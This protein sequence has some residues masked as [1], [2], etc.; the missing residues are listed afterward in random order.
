[1]G[2]LRFGSA[3][4]TAREIDL[5]TPTTAAP[6]GV[7]A[8]I[9]GTA[10]RGPAF[11]PITVG[12]V[13]NFYL[14]FG[15]TDGK[16]FGPLAVTEWLRNAGAVTYM[17]VMG[18]GDGNMRVAD[19]TYAGSVNKAGFV[20]GED[21]PNSTS[22]FLSR[23]PY[24]NYGGPSGRTFF[25]GCLMSESAGSTVFSSAG[26]QQ[27]GVAAPIIRGVIMAA[28]GVIL[29]LS[30]STAASSNA[31][32]ATLVASDANAQGSLTGSVSL[33][34][35][36]TAK[37]E[38]VLLLNGHVGNDSLYPNVISASFDM[39]SNNY[40]A[41]MLNKD[42]LNIQKAGHC[43]YAYWDVYPATAAVTGSGVIATSVG[44]G[45]GAA[46]GFELAA[47][48]T[49]GSV[50]RNTGTATVPNFEN[51]Q[52]R[53][54]YAKTPWIISQRFGGTRYNLFRLH[55]LDAGAGVSNSVKFSIENIAV[56]TDPANKYGTFDIVV[57]S[58]TD[59]DDSPVVLERWSAVDLN[60]S[61]DRY[62]AKV[63]G[64]SYAYFDFDRSE[65]EQKLVVEGQYENV[66][67]YI[68]VEVD[69]NVEN[70]S[71]DPVALP[72]GIRGTHHLVTSGSVPLTALDTATWM[73]N[74]VTPPVPF[75]NDITQ[76]SGATKAVHPT[77]YWGYQFEH[78]TSLATANASAL[79][80][81]SM[82]AHVKYFPDFMTTTVNVIV[83]DNE[84]DVDTTELGVI[85]A[86]RFN[87]NI[88]TL[89]N[90]QVVTGS[91]GLADQQQWVNAT[92]V[93]NGNIVAN[94]ANKT[95]RLQTTDFNQGNKA[96]L[97]FSFFMQGGFDGTNMFDVDEAALNN[98]AIVADIADA[99]RGQALGPN[100]RAYT[101]AI[102]IMGNTVSTDI[103]LLATPGIRVPLITDYALNAT[104]ER[105]DAMYVMDIEE[106]D[107][108]GNLVMSGTQT[109]SVQLTA[110]NFAARGLNSSFGAAYFPDVL[111]TDPNTKT[112]LFVP[113]SVQV[114]GAMALNDAVGHPWFAPAGFTR[115]ALPTALETKIPMDQSNLD[116]LYNVNINPLTAFPGNASSGTNPTGGV[117]VWGQRTTL[118]TA[119]A[120]D[121]VNVRRLLIDIRRQVREIANLIIFE[122]NR[123]STLAKFSAAVTPRLQR[124]QALAGLERFRVM[125][126][127]STTTQADVENN[128]IRGK[129][130]I[131]PTRT[132]E[133]VSLD[134]VVSNNLNQVA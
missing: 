43:L 64:D 57:R 40:F 99:N 28:S 26:L 93:R 55:A 14:E 59:R 91:D 69:S 16:K 8:G 111:M 32:A 78:V 100:V 13:D 56:S 44:A 103:Q 35:G 114:M 58:W 67:Q 126:D 109:T 89:E 18:V 87:N 31:P 3:G 81:D 7:P 96:Y 128:T 2:Q 38:F 97:K 75:R 132:I 65:S 105:F 107:V 33:F 76:G 24:A 29:R 50:A 124:I 5:S 85:D 53:F 22:G 20:V 36:A 123:E 121:R 129:I 108:M 134:F 68:R 45:A 90:L 63:I 130:Y 12:T 113:P 127:S 47:F 46:L 42:P 72:V 11:V 37:Q 21:L 19:G 86:D 112:N 62:I 54:S 23:N 94:D 61:S 39:T 49:T 83:G 95:R 74:A 48:I 80:N 118:Q 84:G 106:I 102:D 131:Q 73:H 119:S 66:S 101:K 6:T 98:N 41:K 116:A 1:M 9:I 52:D 104:A 60:P 25:L 125:I 88:F 92:Y 82:K 71:V 51:F 77:Y 133:F 120:L 117:L 110:N 115:G 15:K 34:A 30:S 17:R 79:A 70:M 4:V 10:N 122:P 27:N